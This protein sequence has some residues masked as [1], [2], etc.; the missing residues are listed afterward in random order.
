[1]KAAVENLSGKVKDT[2]NKFIEENKPKII[3]ALE[4]SN[5]VI[6]YAAKKVIMELL[7]EIKGS[8]VKIISGG[9]VVANKM[10]SNM[11]KFFFSLYSMFLL[12]YTT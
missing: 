10:T 8:V 12:L 1:M 7:V 4:N 2:T 6:I 5:K 11:V 3:S 9:K